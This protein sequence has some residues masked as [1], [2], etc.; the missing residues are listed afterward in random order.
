MASLKDQIIASSYHKLLQK[1]ASGELA[2]GLGNAITLNVNGVDTYLSGS[3]NVIKALTVTGSIIPEGSGSWDLGSEDNPF[4]DLYISSASIKLID[5]DARAAGKP[6][7][8]YL[9]VLNKTIVDDLISGKTIKRVDEIT[10]EKITP[11]E[12]VSSDLVPTQAFVYDANRDLM[13]LEETRLDNAIWELSGD[14]NDLFLKRNNFK[15]AFMGS[16][17]DFDDII[18]G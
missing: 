5:H 7:S 2:D 10:R 8:E 1:S 4:K 15:Y 17:G 13:P 18:V 9:T 11:V 16:G 12:I 14:G 6:R 3:T